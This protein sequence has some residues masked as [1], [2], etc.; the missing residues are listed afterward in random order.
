MIRCVYDIRLAVKIPILG[1][2][3]ITYGRDAIEMMMA[4]AS[5]I[6]VGTAVYY[7]GKEA[8]SQIADE[9]EKWMKEHG[10]SDYKEIIGAVHQN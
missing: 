7:R 10:Y 1:T 4:G 9:M 2:G 5:A 3:G 8:F 6:G